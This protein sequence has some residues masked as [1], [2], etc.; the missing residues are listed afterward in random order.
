MG[1]AASQARL[2]SITRRIS[3]NELRAQLINNEK[4]RLAT[5]S[6]KVSENYISA[7]NSTNLM[8][9]NY[10]ANNA[11][12]TVPLSYNALTSFNQY[13]NQYVLS[14][15][16][17]AVFLREDEA[18]LYAESNHN[19]D[20]Y[21]SLHGI[22]YTS[23]Y[24][25]VI[26]DK[27]REENYGD[28]A[29]YSAAIQEAAVVRAWYETIGVDALSSVSGIENLS[30]FSALYTLANRIDAAYEIYN[31]NYTERNLLI[32]RAVTAMVDE[33]EFASYFSLDDSHSGF[34]LNQGR[35][36]G[37]S[38]LSNSWG[39]NGYVNQFFTLPWPE[40][41]NPTDL[42][43][44][45][46]NK[47]WGVNGDSGYDNLGNGGFQDI[48]AA[49]WCY[50]NNQPI[51]SSIDISTLPSNVR[52]LL[53]GYQPNS[54]IIDLDAWWG[55][56]TH[57]T[58]Y[59]VF[60]RD[61]NDP[62]PP[63]Q[64]NYMFVHYTGY[65][66][67]S[68]EHNDDLWVC[69]PPAT[70]PN[71]LVYDNTTYPGGGGSGLNTNNFIEYYVDGQLF[72]G[73]IPDA[74]GDPTH[75]TY[76]L[77][78]PCNQTGSYSYNQLNQQYGG[79]ILVANPDGSFPELNSTTPRDDATA[80]MRSA[81]KEYLK[82]M[83][84][85]GERIQTEDQKD[86]FRALGFTDREIEIINTPP[87]EILGSELPDLIEEF[88]DLFLGAGNSANNWT[89]H[90]LRVYTDRQNIVGAVQTVREIADALHTYSVNGLS[91]ICFD[92]EVIN[93]YA[94]H[95]PPLN[96][97]YYDPETAFTSTEL[98]DE[99]YENI[100]AALSISSASSD[101]ISTKPDCPG[102]FW[103]QF[104][105]YTSS[106]PDPQIYGELNNIMNTLGFHNNIPILSNSN[107]IQNE[108][109]YV[110]AMDF[111][112]R[113]GMPVYGYMKN[114]ED[115]TA[116]AEWYTNLFNKLETSG[117]KTLE[118]GLASST[119]WMRFALENGIGIIEQLN[120][121]NHWNKIMYNSCS[122]I[123]EETSSQRTTLAEAE[124]NKAMNQIQA[125]DQ[126]LDLELKNIDTEHSSLQQEYESVKKAMTD[127]I[128]RTFKLY[129]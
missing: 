26:A 85:L 82:S 76:Y 129:T 69:I 8:F 52:N 124:Y 106:N 41:S 17:G 16:T 102:S 36:T 24:W 44:Q 75:V 45:C 126:R 70:N 74:S 60:E 77:P 19:L 93:S 89:A 96:Y 40:Y 25:D 50:G 6:S 112:G 90:G 32:S 111:F 88:F 113:H 13:N 103:V 68:M 109:A 53:E 22:E 81:M 67:S 57:P 35:S 4:M 55:S 110:A 33:S 97:N 1:L 5:E 80:Y 64:G 98:T 3:D 63:E 83:L 86:R 30:T 62:T 91:S 121:D 79:G 73:Y 42:D 120:T 21:L 59:G 2:L 66:E 116:E 95:E 118:Y 65:D 37:F 72:Y 28:D 56:G 10:A 84:R 38:Y 14:D 101:I 27:I 39:T 105:N 92:E 9:T 71:T 107:V 61:I 94:S 34:W 47:W 114:G 58:I 128:G 104:V 125:K 122:D 119:D 99:D 123:T 108:L 18:R 20:D 46:A 115:A 127:N 54:H 51:P 29:A 78:D 49:L 12:Q 7:L 23:T 117:F 100:L 11:M 87:E 48:Y 31:G 43:T 15:V